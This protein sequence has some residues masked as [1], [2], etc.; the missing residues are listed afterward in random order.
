MLSSKVCDGN[1]PIVHINDIRY[2]IFQV[3]QLAIRTFIVK[4]D[5]MIFR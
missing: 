3:G 2:H 4:R 5:L 1:P